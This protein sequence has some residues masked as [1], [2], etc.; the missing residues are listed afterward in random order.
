MTDSI[1]RL[2]FEL[3]LG[4][5]AEQERAVTG[6]RSCA[7][8]VLGA[9]SIAG[10]FLGARLGGRSLDAWGAL[11]TVS[12]ALCF[13]SAIWVLVPRDLGLSFRGQGLTADGETEPGVDL[14]EGYRAACRWIESQ[15]ELNGR[16]IDRLSGWLTISC[17]LLATEILLWTISLTS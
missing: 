9:A 7:G 12:F 3:T 2:S 5:V 15:L 10:S 8:T 4:A 16:K 13:G 11:A 17:G 6:L 1:E 14:A